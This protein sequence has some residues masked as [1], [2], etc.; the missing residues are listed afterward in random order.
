MRKYIIVSILFCFISVS[1]QSASS[2]LSRLQLA[3]TNVSASGVISMKMLN[4]S[5]ELLR[6]WDES[7]S[8]GAFRWRVIVR[9]NHRTT[10]WFQD[11]DGFMFTKNQPQF[12][13]IDAGSAITKK[14]DVKSGPWTSQEPGSRL[15][16]ERG[17][18]VTVVYDVPPSQEA[19]AKDVWYG[20]VADSITVP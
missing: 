8:W 15:A 2:A 4:R 3:I 7:N 1:G 12:Q 5:E 6:V 13:E 19:T 9:H 20:V 10:T 11:A 16:L 18:T 17:D 14:L